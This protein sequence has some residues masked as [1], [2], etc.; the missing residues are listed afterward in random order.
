MNYFILIFT[1]AGGLSAPTQFKM[2]GVARLVVAFMLGVTLILSTSNVSA[3]DP[4]RLSGMYDRGFGEDEFDSQSLLRDFNGQEDELWRV[5]SRLRD[6][7][8]KPREITLVKPEKP[9]PPMHLH[10][11]EARERKYFLNF[12]P[13]GSPFKELRS[14]SSGFGGRIHPIQKKYRLH[15]GVDFGV[16][17]GTPIHATANGIVIVATNAGSS[18]YGKYVVVRH[19]LGFSS[20]YAHLSEINV[21]PGEYISKGESL[22]RSGNTGKSTGP[23]LH[24][25]VKYFGQALNPISFLTWSHE[26]YVSIFSA[27]KAVPWSA[28]RKQYA[29]LPQVAGLPFFPTDKH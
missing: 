20:L 10:E 9:L 1:V 5:E 6:S 29:P 23:H 22:G 27:E 18:G 21:K 16:S 17:S 15:N 25:E 19:G 24:Y 14:V 7:G 26:N 2:N 13:N 11:A 12:V 28:L 3:S 8:W 4:F